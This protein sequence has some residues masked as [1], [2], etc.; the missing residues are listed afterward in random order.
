MFKKVVVSLVAGAIVTGSVAN[1]YAMDATSIKDAGMAT[2][3]EGIGA[4]TT[5]KVDAIKLALER[6]PNPCG[7]KGVVFESLLKDKLN[8]LHFFDKDFNA[9]INTIQNDSCADI[10]IKDSV[11]NI[12]KSIQCKDTTSK[13]GISQLIKQVEDGKYSNTTLIGTKE[14]AK[15]FNKAAA[16]NGLEIRMAN[17]G[18]STKTTSQV[19]D[20]VVDARL[21]SMGNLGLNLDAAAKAS[22]KAGILGAIL[23][24]GIST[25]EAISEDMDLDEAISHITVSTTAEFAASAGTGYVVTL[26]VSGLATAGISTVGIVILPL[27]IGGVTHWIL[28]S[29]LENIFDTVD[30][31]SKLTTC[32]NHA[33]AWV[34]DTSTNCV[35]TIKA[36]YGSL[37]QK[38]MGMANRIRLSKAEA[39]SL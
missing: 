13:S 28:A 22:L 10:Y 9:C 17:S 38:A 31:E 21:R 3:I 15:L 39:V 23:E 32:F 29:T 35:I 8:L 24:A 36:V 16:D 11:G 18:I 19:A 5:S 2:I 7:A 20:Q 26:A 4:F 37:S 27:A 33:G 6:C 30:L 34:K 12:I 25:Y 1:A 14:C